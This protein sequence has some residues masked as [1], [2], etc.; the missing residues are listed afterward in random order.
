M[1]LIFIVDDN[2]ELKLIQEKNNY[3]FTVKDHMQSV[4][5]L[6]VQ[7]SLQVWDCELEPKHNCW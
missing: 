7:S 6:I 2:L 1:S 3:Q 5:D 4:L